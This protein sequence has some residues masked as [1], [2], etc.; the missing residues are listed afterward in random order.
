MRGEEIQAGSSSTAASCRLAAVQFTPV[1]GKGKNI[2]YPLPE[3]R[4]DCRNEDVMKRSS[5]RSYQP[6]IGK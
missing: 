4:T 3:D 5:P 6:V 1:E 2:L